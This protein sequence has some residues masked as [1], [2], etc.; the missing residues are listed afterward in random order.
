[1]V[2]TLPVPPLVTDAWVKATWEDVL[3]LADYP[4]LERAR[5]YYDKGY[6]RAETTPTGSG[7]SQDNTLLSRTVS[8]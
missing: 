3:A 5:F 4:E 7:H 2:N 8:L 6:M 1:M